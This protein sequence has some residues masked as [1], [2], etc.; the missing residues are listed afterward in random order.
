MNYKELIAEASRMSDS[1]N[2]EE[3]IAI[4]HKAINMDVQEPDAY[5]EQALLYRRLGELDH[6]ISRFEHVT[7]LNSG[8]ASVFNNLGVLCYEAERWHEAIHNLYRALIIDFGYADAWYN[9]G[10]VFLHLGAMDNAV[11]AWQKCLSISHDHKEILSTLKR[12]PNDKVRAITTAIPAIL[13]TNGVAETPFT[14]S[15]EWYDKAYHIGRVGVDWKKF[16]AVN[17]QY[18]QSGRRARW[19]SVLDEIQIP[20]RSIEW[21]EVGC[22][23]GLTAYWTAERFPQAR[24]HMFDF[25]QEAVSWCKRQFPFPDRTVVWHGSVE[26]IQLPHNDLKEL[27]DFASCVDVTEHLPPPVYKA[28]IGELRRVLKPGGYLVL[29]QGNAPNVEHIHVLPENELVADFLAAGFDLVKYLP[30]R[31]YLLKKSLCASSIYTIGD[32]HAEFAF[33]NIPNIKHIAMYSM[34]IYQITNK[35]IDFSF[36]NIPPSGT[37]ICCFGEIDVRAMI[38]KQITEYKRDEDE[39]IRDLVARYMKSLEINKNTYKNIWIMSVVPPVKYNKDNYY[40]KDSAFR[41]SDTD[42]SRYCNKLNTILKQEC[43]KNNFHYFDIY[44]LY[45]DENGMLIDRLS[46]G[47][48]HINDNSL[49]LGKLKHDINTTPLCPPLLTSGI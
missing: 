34:S 29:M 49:L 47:I 15:Q 4:C 24:F 39:I 23:L 28:M 18:E 38:H 26:R 37:V 41:G 2:L 20:E 3:A 19:E 45:A 43:I 35:P 17:L 22:H 30:Y 7:K 1:G 36:Y 6:A 10:R 48:V 46:D 14:Y 13:A 8:D 44:N 31:H 21:L 42:R 25:S 11:F 9:L 33:K 32:S 16:S 40:L 12:L 5:Y 27:F